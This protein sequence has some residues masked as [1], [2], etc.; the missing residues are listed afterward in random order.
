M[1]RSIVLIL[2]PL[3]FP[4]RGHSM[5]Q[6]KREHQSPKRANREGNTQ[7]KNRESERELDR[8]KGEIMR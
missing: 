3:V 2:S 6:G 1:R 7:R 8:V 4:G 5:K